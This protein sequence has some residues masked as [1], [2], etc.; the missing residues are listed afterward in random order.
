[1]TQAES[2]Y[3]ADDGISGM[4]MYHRHMA[5]IANPY[6][7]G[8]RWAPE[9]LALCLKGAQEAGHATFGPFQGHVALQRTWTWNVRTAEENSDV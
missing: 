9:Q 2:E 6:E 3:G 5:T 4:E 8:R 1:M 7:L